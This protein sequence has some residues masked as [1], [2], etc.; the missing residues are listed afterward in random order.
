MN[1]WMFWRKRNG[2]GSF[3]KGLLDL[4]LLSHLSY[5]SAIATAGVSRTVIFEEASR[6]PYVS[7]RYFR[8]VHGL[9]SNLNY[10]YAEAC[11]LVG[12]A[13]EVPEVKSLLLRLSSSL[14]AGEPEA[15][16][17]AREAHV[18]AEFYGN[19]Y[20]RQLEST[21]KWTDS[22]VALIVSA[23]LII[24]V[25]VISM[26]IYQ[27]SL[28]YLLG[29]AGVTIAVTIAG[30]W[31][32]DRSAPTEPKTHSLPDLSREQRLARTLFKFLLPIAVIAIAPPE[33]ILDEFSP[34]RNTRGEP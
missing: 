7:A 25:A 10:D 20:E 33:K 14:S 28:I 26:M 15:D 3:N 23:A 21:K 1:S 16:F 13:A 4:D 9:C 31:T 19:K 29:L 22:Y 34:R 12:E 30:A 24:I 27:T 6:L 32:I 2:K 17:F 18:H 8:N 11:Q 5:M